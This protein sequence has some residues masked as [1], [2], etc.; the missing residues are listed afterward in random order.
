MKKI[1][2][3]CG[4]FSTEREIS[5]KTGQAVARGIFIAGYESFFMDTAFPKEVYTADKNFKYAEKGDVKNTPENVLE[6]SKQLV[7]LKPDKVF[8]GLHGGEGENGEI[9]ALLQLL[10]IPYVGSDHKT[11]AVCMDKNMSKVIAKSVSVPTAKWEFI[12]EKDYSIT[13]LKKLLKPYGYPVVIKALGQGS[14]VGV[15][16]IHSEK[17]LETTV[18]M[19]KQVKDRYF[20]EEY[21]NGRE[22]SIPVIKGHA[23]HSIE[24]IPNEGF[25]DYEHKYT[26][27]VTTHVCPAELT[28]KQVKILNSYAEK[29]YTAVGCKDYARIDFILSEKDGKFYF[30]EINNLPGMTELSLVPESA[31]ASGI[32]FSELMVLLLND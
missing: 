12:S 26:P 6:L 13:A 3:I 20:I 25:Y 9:Q 2:T 17:D 30:L 24:L 32:S 31:K 10:Q 22:L 1:L 21:I 16:I 8:V 29:I 14:S 28:D 19:M 7:K 11:S 5:L 23:F 27:G 4:G 18:K 15:S